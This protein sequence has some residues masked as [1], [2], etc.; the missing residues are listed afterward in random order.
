MVG[1]GDEGC[2]AVGRRRVGSYSGTS[3]AWP[4]LPL[5]AQPGADARCRSRAT[6]DRNGASGGDPSFARCEGAQDG[7]GRLR[8]R[9]ASGG[10]D[11]EKDEYEMIKRSTKDAKRWF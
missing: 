4:G 10:A 9:P 6:G 8:R 11:G 3:A 5:D 2:E 1:V 7:A